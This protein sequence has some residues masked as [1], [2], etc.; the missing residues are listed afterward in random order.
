MLVCNTLLYQHPFVI[1]LKFTPMQILLTQIFKSIVKFLKVRCSLEMNSCGIMQPYFVPYI[2]YFQLMDKCT[3]W[4]VFNNTQF[5]DKGWIN[6]NRITNVNHSKEHLWFTIPIKKSFRANIKNIQVADETNWK[7]KLISQ[8]FTI[9]KRSKYF[10]EANL[11]LLE[12]LEFDTGSLS[13]FLVNSLEV[14]RNALDIKTKMYRQDLDFIDIHPGLDLGAGT[15]ALV[16]SQALGAKI[17]IN[18]IGGKHLFDPKIYSA[19]GTS[20]NYFEEETPDILTNCSYAKY[21]ILEIIARHGLSLTRDFIKLG[22][23]YAADA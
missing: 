19:G 17:Y 7:K 13:E 5:I 3:S 2:G 15:W 20:L 10:D 8:F 6:R 12:I 21:S 9:Q 4:I 14:L 11:I 22:K 18:P 16:L 23:V 1:L